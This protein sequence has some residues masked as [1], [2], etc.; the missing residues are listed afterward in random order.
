MS[1]ILIIDD[2]M[3]INQLLG[4]VV[5]RMGHDYRSAGSAQSSA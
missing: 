2:D 3:T 4:D 1:K 5:T